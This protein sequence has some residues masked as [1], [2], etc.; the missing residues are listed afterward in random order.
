MRDK[1]QAPGEILLDIKNVS[2]GYE[3]STVLNGVSLTV[4]EGE[5][6]QYIEFVDNAEDV[7]EKLRTRL[8]LN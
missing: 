6:S 5:V 8:G 7:V 3:G 1:H 2:A 4:R